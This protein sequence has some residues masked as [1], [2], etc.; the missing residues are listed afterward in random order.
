MRV[1][2]LGTYGG[3]SAALGLYAFED[4][5]VDPVVVNPS[6]LETAMARALSHAGSA[7]ALAHTADGRPWTHVAD[8]RD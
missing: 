5:A 7:R 6:Q 2:T 4:V 1:T 8:R 3:P